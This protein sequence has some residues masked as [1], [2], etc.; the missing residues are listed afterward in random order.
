MTEKSVIAHVDIVADELRTLRRLPGPL[1][2]A[3]MLDA[4]VI[5]DGRG[6]ARLDVALNRMLLVV[7][8][9]RNDQD[10]LAAI[11]TMGGIGISQKR[12]RT[13]SMTTSSTR[14]LLHGLFVVEV[15]AES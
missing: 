2:E 6:R 14:T 4:L 12:S 9:N 8:R 1:N 13:D 11:A 3:T 5:V 10:L 7:R 15:I